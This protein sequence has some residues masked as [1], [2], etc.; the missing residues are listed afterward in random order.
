MT[1]KAGDTQIAENERVRVQGSK[2][3][4]LLPDFFIV[5]IYNVS[6][7]DYSSIVDNKTLSVFGS[8]GGLLCTGEIDDI[9]K[10]QEGANMISTLAVVDGKSFWQTSISETV[11][12]G[13]SVKTTYQH[14]LKNASVGSFTASDVRLVR[15]QTF[16]GRLAECVSELARSVH[17]RAY[18]TN[19]AVY[20]TSNG[21][22]SEV[23]ALNDDDIVLDQDTA[24]G[25]RMIKTVVK[26]YP[27]GALV[28]TG[29]SKYRLASQKFDADNFEGAWNSYLVLVNE[30]MLSGGGMEGG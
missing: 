28:E 23:V 25:T 9:Y 17:G 15:G 18:I 4:T 1:V 7:E 2:N 6:D 14:I 16:S 26:G 12:A 13:S 5:D 29:G 3:M 10:R 11:G 27:V 19:G 30:E 8:D 24:T 21:N 22:A 20:I